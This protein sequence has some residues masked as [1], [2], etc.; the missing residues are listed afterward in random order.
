MSLSENERVSYVSTS[1]S[2][3]C[4][5]RTVLPTLVR[6]HYDTGYLP[7]HSCRQSLC[8]TPW[9]KLGKHLGYATMDSDTRDCW[10]ASLLRLYSITTQRSQWHWQLPGEPYQNIADMAGRHPYIRRLYLRGHRYHPL[11]AH[12][13]IASLYLS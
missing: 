6:H 3:P 9:T 1:K 10:R 13:Q 11:P 7:G 4:A 8:R 5:V 12:T 2:Y